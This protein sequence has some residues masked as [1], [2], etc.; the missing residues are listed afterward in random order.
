MKNVDVRSS[1]VHSCNVLRPGIYHLKFVTRQIDRKTFVLQAD[2][3]KTYTN[4]TG[5]PCLREYVGIKNVIHNVTANCTW[6]ISNLAIERYQF[7]KCEEQNKHFVTSSN[8]WKELFCQKDLNHIAP[9]DDLKLT[10]RHVH[11][12]CVNDNITIEGK[13]RNCPPFVFKLPIDVSWKLGKYSSDTFLESVD[14]TVMSEPLADNITDHWVRDIHE[15]APGDLFSKIADLQGIIDKFDPGLL[16]L[17]SPANQVK[18]LKQNNEI[19]MYTLAC[20]GLITILGS[21]LALFLYIKYLCNFRK[22][23][24]DNI[25]MTN[26]PPP[27]PSNTSQSGSVAYGTCP[28]PAGNTYLTIN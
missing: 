4:L 18:L 9:A 6:P 2:P 12:Y 28:S 7:A 17:S 10:K 1:I 19:M 5:K 22:L 13:S 25:P 15:E 11:F 3:F 27:P 24:K 21:V 16:H 20:I 26:L 14:L 23:S 8:D